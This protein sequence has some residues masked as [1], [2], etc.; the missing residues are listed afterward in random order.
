MDIIEQSGGAKK[1]LKREETVAVQD[2][3]LTIKFQEQDPRK[4]DPK[5]CGIEVKL[6]GSHYAHAVAGGPYSAVDTDANG[7][8]QVAVNGG[9]SHT[10]GPGQVLTTFTWRRAAAII[11][12]GE[13]ALLALPV[14]QHTVTLT[15]VD[16]S[17][18]TNTDTTLVT[19][20]AAG[21]PS[22]TSVSPNSGSLAGGTGV[23]LSGFS[24]GSATAVQFG[25]ATLSGNAITVV[26]DS[27]I[28]VTSPVS[29]VG[30]PAA[31]SVTTPAG[32]SNSLLFT[33]VGTVP[34][35][36]TTKKLIDNFVS[37][38]AIAFGP[39]GKLYVGNR[40][41]QLGKFT[42]NDK[43]DT[44]VSSVIATITSSTRGIHGIAFDPAEHGDTVFP[45]VYISTSQIF[46]SESRN[47]IGAAIN[48]NIQAVRGA[49][50]DQVTTLVDG[51]PVSRTDH[52]V[53][54]SCW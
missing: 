9:G 19:V 43:F 44:V 8:Q 18:D 46:H 15:V 33:Y 17:G 6:I 32:E 11:G 4:G 7:V 20:F 2:G 27:T 45:T 26:N 31:V 16:S 3:K 22:L 36:F 51:M 10:H 39:D 28:R 23:T 38:T 37:P 24:F 35:S 13:V 40:N 21:H 50:L 42:L 30:V 53:S 54:K 48:G 12:T 41:G 34:I 25:L 14:G 49:N 29:G 52:S 1:A 47:S 5:I